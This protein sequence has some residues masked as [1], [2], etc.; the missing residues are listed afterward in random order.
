MLTGTSR[1]LFCGAKTDFLRDIDDIG[2]DDGMKSN[3]LEALV[4]SYVRLVL[5][6]DASFVLQKLCSTLTA[7]HHRLGLFWPLPVRHILA[8]LIN[9]AFVPQSYL[10]DLPQIILAVDRIPAKQSQG[11]VRFLLTLIEDMSSRSATALDSL[12]YNPSSSFLDAVQL[13]DHCFGQFWHN[14]Q[15]D[16]SNRGSIN[17]DLKPP[18]SGYTTDLIALCLQALPVCYP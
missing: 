8:C 6:D 18:S 4:V 14:Q 1:K 13:L 9:Q 2:A 7:L 12:V 3:L 10:P 17:G 16:L 11:A 15:P 5:A